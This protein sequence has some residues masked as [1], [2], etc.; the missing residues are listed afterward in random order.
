VAGVRQ[1]TAQGV[2]KPGETVVGILTGNL[3]KDP[4]ATVDYHTGQWP[5]ARYANAPVQ[6]ESTLTGVRAVIE[7]RL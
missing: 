2:I 3:M 6:V 4:A 7:R 5:N 1:L